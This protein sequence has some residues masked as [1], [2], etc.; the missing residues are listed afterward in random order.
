MQHVPSR[1]P[2]A[3]WLLLR[4]RP[5]SRT[6][7]ARRALLGAAL[8]AAAD[9]VGM[10]PEVPMLGPCVKRA[11]MGARRTMAGAAW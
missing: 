8:R 11:C 9:G 3:A 5:C 4:P 2:T 10:D 7:H 6:L 1:A